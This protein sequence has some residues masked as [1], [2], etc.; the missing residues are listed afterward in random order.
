MKFSDRGDLFAYYD[1]EGQTVR[2]VSI[3]SKKKDD[4]T[5]LI[6]KIVA[7]DFRTEFTA[8]AECDLSFIKSIEFDTQSQYFVGYG[9]RRVFV[10]NLGTAEKILYDLDTEIYDKIYTI[11]FVSSPPGA[12]GK[13]FECMIG[14][15]KVGSK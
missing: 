2:I 1:V 11:R 5:E 10:L 3:G 4:I 13:P 7:G 8:T 12:S 6:N 9:D 15:S 14:C